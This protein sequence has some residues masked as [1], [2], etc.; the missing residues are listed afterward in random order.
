MIGM[1]VLGLVTF[2]AMCSRSLLVSNVVMWLVTF[3]ED[4]GVIRAKRRMLLESYLGG[5]STLRHT[6]DGGVDARQT[7]GVDFSLVT[8]SARAAT[9]STR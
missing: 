7:L 3:A 1:L 5:L 9:S 8:R 6:R 2:A 4:C